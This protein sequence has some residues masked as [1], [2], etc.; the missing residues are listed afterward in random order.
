MATGLNYGPRFRGPAVTSRPSG[1][2]HEYIPPALKYA[3]DQRRALWA[4]KSHSTQRNKKEN[5]ISL[6]NKPKKQQADPYYDAERH[7]VDRVEQACKLICFGLEEI[8]NVPP[9]KNATRTYKTVDQSY[10]LDQVQ[11]ICTH[12]K[13]PMPQMSVERKPGVHKG[14]GSFLCMNCG[15]KVTDSI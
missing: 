5:G 15:V 10:I 1:Y 8:S 7:L 12:I 3:T 4:A 6:S 2:N 9:P 14:K 11:K 13:V